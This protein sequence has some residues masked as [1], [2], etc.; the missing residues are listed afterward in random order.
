V[1]VCVC[2]RVCVFLMEVGF[3]TFQPQAFSKIGQKAE[4]LTH[5]FGVF[6]QQ[7]Q[8]CLVLCSISFENE[9]YF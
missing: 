4:F 1:A 3:S 9:S 7:V 2:A 5:P 8:S 6:L